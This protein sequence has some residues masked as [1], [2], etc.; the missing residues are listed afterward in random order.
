MR[1]M[2]GVLVVMLAGCN[3]PECPA[4]S[5]G[6]LLGDG[7]GF[8]CEAICGFE[9]NGP[10]TAQGFAASDLDPCSD[11]GSGNTWVYPAPSQE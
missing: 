4:H 7:G 1:T 10:T 3:A 9:A 6:V 2:L 11:G 5:F 8:A